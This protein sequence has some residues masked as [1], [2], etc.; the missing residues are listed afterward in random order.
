MVLHHG[1]IDSPSSSSLPEL[2]VGHHQVLLIGIPE[3]VLKILLKLAPKKETSGNLLDLYNLLPPLIEVDLDI[4]SRSV[5]SIQTLD[6]HTR[7][8]PLEDS[9]KTIDIYLQVEQM[10]F[11][12]LLF[13]VVWDVEFHE[14]VKTSESVAEGSIFDTLFVCDYEVVECKKRLDA[15]DQ[16]VTVAWD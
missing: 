8:I 7:R 13:S 3:H 5:T 12:T 15:V 2:N 9:P 10:L 6:E 11:C 4:V 16:E 1:V 14:L